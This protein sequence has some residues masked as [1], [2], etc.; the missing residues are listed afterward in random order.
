VATVVARRRH[1]SGT[2]TGAETELRKWNWGAFLLAP[3]WALGHRLWWHAAVA[4]LLG[5]IPI[6]GITI[7][8]AF[9][10]RGNRW[11]WARGSYESVEEFRHRERN[12][13][14]AGLIVLGVLVL[15][16]AASA[17]LG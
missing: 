17:A 5:W 7:A 9:G 11:A 10:L 14:K 13:V 3:F 1:R 6:A 4:I 12:W 2:S 16:V 15:L 8:I